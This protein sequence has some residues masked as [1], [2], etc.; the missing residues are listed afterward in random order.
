ML[1]DK[2]SLNIYVYKLSHMY[3]II[4]VL[5]LNN[6]FLIFISLS[7]QKGKPKDFDLF[8]FFCFASFIHGAYPGAP[9]I[10]YVISEASLLF[11]DNNYLSISGLTRERSHNKGAMVAVDRFLLFHLHLLRPM[12]REM[13]GNSPPPLQWR[14]NVL[15]TLQELPLWLPKHIPQK[16]KETQRQALALALH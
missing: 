2:F 1:H 10:N 9:P 13:G 8:P 15:L 4:R 12:R 5:I 3:S 11:L 6:H 7:K 14:Y 16:F